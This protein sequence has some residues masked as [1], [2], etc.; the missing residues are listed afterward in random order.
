MPNIGLVTENKTKNCYETRSLNNHWNGFRFDKNGEIIGERI[1]R[2][3]P[4]KQNQF[5]G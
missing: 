5:F 1:S 3:F 4:S 2:D